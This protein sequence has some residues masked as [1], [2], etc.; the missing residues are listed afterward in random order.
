MCGCYTFV[1]VLSIPDRHATRIREGMSMKKGM[2]GLLAIVLL[3]GCESV[4]TSTTEGAGASQNGGV[5]F[6][7]GNG[8]GSDST[9]TTTTASGD[10]NATTEED[11]GGVIFGSGN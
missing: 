1:R 2:A 6:G 11:R 5:I 8:A 10:T 9:A 4:P 7:S 3:A